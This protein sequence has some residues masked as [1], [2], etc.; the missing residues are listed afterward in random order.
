MASTEQTLAAATQHHRAGELGAAA[1]L[2]R[3]ILARQPGHALV[4]FRLGLIDLQSERPAAAL[5]LIEQAVAS[6]PA[7]PRYRHGLG[8][9]LLALGRW[10]EA[11]AV[12]R[13]LASEDPA[14][15]D[16]RFSLGV[17][18]QSQGL[19]EEA[20]V[21][22]ADALAIDDSLAEAENNLG[23]CQQERGDL[24]AA[25]VNYRRAL[26]LR[27]EYAG[28]MSN[29]GTVLRKTARADAAISLL[30]A[31][32]G[33][34]PGVGA[35]RLNLGA[36]LCALSLYADARSIL[37]PLA[38]AEPGNAEALFNLANSLQGLGLAD[39]AADAYGQALAI[40]PAHVDA[41]INLGNLQ[42]SRGELV[43]ALE[44]YE[45]ALRQRPDSVAATNNKGC[46]LRSLGRIEDA[47]ST[48][49]AGLDVAGPHSVLLDNL[50]SVLKDGGDLDGAIE[51]YRSAVRLDPENAAA[52]GNLAYTL[53]FQANQ[54][55]T[56]RDECA[57]WGDKFAAPL[58]TSIRLHG[59]E[60]SPDR[61]L[62]IGY[63]SPDFRDHCQ[64]LFMFP[65]LQH[66]DHSQCEIVCYS[67]VERR[68]E[69]T[70]SMESLPDKWR[71]VRSL[72]DAAL[73]EV[74]RADGIDLLVDLTMHMA[75]GRPLL[76]ARKPAPVQIAW[77]AYPGTTGIRAIDYRLT[78]PCLDSGE[79][80]ADYTERS[81]R[82]P[83]SFW[84]YDARSS[85]AVCD[86]VPAASR[87]HI[88]FGCLNNP[89]K[90]TDATL[91]LWSGVLARLPDARLLL[92]APTGRF[93]TWMLGRLARRGIDGRR[94]DF[95]AFRP[96][97]EYLATYHRI[98]IGLDTVP[99]NGHTTSLDALWMGVPVVS[100]IGDTCVGRG[101]LSQLSQLE[102]T[103]FATRTDQEFIDVAVRL[104]REPA[105]LAALRRS[106]RGRMTA[107]SLMDGPRFV[108]GLEAAY[109]QAW[110]AY[111]AGP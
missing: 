85:E 73:A 21:A 100:R 51:C 94:I 111:C 103:E 106:L 71:E 67:S 72:D 8:Q 48:F 91:D 99:Y 69:V 76:F 4:S 95:V 110:R 20:A 30:R 24:A 36:A 17:A 23:I 1:E 107:S 81:I 28:A 46:V 63:V 22:Y 25:E 19:F 49:R 57:R 80:L 70:R 77:L 105:R 78:D 66:H 86:E 11:A 9:V 43:R 5:V 35:H 15:A 108:R 68:D 101:G 82:L 62:R 98:D 74:I 29:L 59:N 90:V 12:Y 44:T 79:M 26:R 88:T 58:G 13:R 96:R 38:A 10:P 31:A 7:E 54:G 104:A 14:S 65:V 93:R 92:M 61:R 32:V 47:E 89:C 33:L 41:L 18:L 27:P 97:S 39:A 84:C 55:S 2:Y 53:S 56:V 102:L 37:E 40:Q 16:A 50:G 34:E 87:G 52:H 60:R 83:D 42:R 64:S 45:L 109:R 6:E 3:G 75:N